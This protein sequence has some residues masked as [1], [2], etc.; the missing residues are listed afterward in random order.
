M[1]EERYYMSK[2]KNKLRK[3]TAV[4]CSVDWCNNDTN[5]YPS[6][7][8]RQNVYCFEHRNGI[9]FGVNETLSFIKK[10]KQENDGN[11]PTVRE[12][13]EGTP[14]S[15]TQVRLRLKNLTSRGDI[16][17]VGK[18]KMIIVNSTDGKDG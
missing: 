3:R 15:L 6:I 11:S 16:S 7:A 5:K 9:S 8:K 13:A 2:K 12:I 18:R 4:K 10:F 1:K 17:F 14:L